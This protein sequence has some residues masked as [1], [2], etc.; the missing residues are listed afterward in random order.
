MQLINPYNRD[1]LK[2]NTLSAIPFPHFKIDN[3]LSADFA[4][5]IFDSFPSHEFTISKGK[6]FTKLNEKGKTQLTDSNFFPAPVKKLNEILAA[7]N[8]LDDMSFVFD[9][10]KLLPDHNLVGGGI[11]QTGSK[12]RLDVHIDFN[13]IAERDLHRRLNI[14]IYFNK[15]WKSEWGGNI[16]L[17]DKEVK[18]CH[19][20]FEPIFNR[21]VVFATNEISYHGVTEIK[22]PEGVTR[23][24]FAAYYYTNYAPAYYTKDHSTIFRARPDEVIR[25]K[26]LMPIEK[27][28]DSVQQAVQGIKKTI[29]SII[30]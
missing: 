1:E 3:F 4:N 16:E 27:F 17:W 2:A 20:S 8:F 9:I 25:G 11:H 10:P 30:K 24:S 14:L 15:E 21:C 22:C 6:Q 7:Q 12:G 28:S 19:Q 18:T 13:R 26:V 29:K 23:K 5:Q